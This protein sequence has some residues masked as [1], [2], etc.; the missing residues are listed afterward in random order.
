MT[1]TP[2]IALEWLASDYRSP[3]G[4]RG[5]R[6]KSYGPSPRWFRFR[7]FPEQID[8]VDNG[9]PYHT[10][11]PAQSRLVVSAIQSAARRSCSN[12]LHL[13][14]CV[15]ARWQRLTGN[16]I[17][18]KRATS[19]CYLLSRS[20][21]GAQSICRVNKMVRRRPEPNGTCADRPRHITASLP[22]LRR[23]SIVL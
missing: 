16:I 11:R 15:S 17:S 5:R 22:E 3:R 23:Q 19:R 14:A 6:P 2:Q 10:N 9:W 4:H 1:M 21:I 20:S 8:V 7:L 12:S 13:C 18:A